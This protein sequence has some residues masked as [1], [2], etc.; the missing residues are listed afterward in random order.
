MHRLMQ[1]QY[2]RTIVHPEQGPVA[3]T[4]L[5]VPYEGLAY[6][7]ARISD[8]ARGSGLGLTRAFMSCLVH[9]RFALPHLRQVRVEVSIDR[10]EYLRWI[11]M[12]GFESESIKREAGPR[13]Q[14]LVEFVLWIR[15]S[16]LLLRR[17]RRTTS[18]CGV[19][20]LAGRRTS[21]STTAV[22]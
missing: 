5:I 19:T 18:R 16:R 8:E 7:W 4:G 9:A 21:A 20:T 17:R 1:V 3:A 6:G 15:E 12:L 11:K 2:A 14:D 10:P 13:G 22:S